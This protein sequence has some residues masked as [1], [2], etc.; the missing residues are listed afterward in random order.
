M[1]RRVS[2]PNRK[3][4]EQENRKLEIAI[5]ALEDKLVSTEISYL[6]LKF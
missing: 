6:T 2:K 3:L 4:F 5:K 1:E